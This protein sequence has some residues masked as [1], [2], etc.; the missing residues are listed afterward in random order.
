M[1]TMTAAQRRELE[2]RAFLAAMD[3]CPSRRVLDALSDKWVTLILHAL[4]EGPLRRGDLSRAVVGATQKVLTQTLRTL[5]REGYLTRTIVPSGPVRVE[6]ELTPLGHD[7]LG[8]VRTIRDWA[9]THI[10]EIE[11][12]QAGERLAPVA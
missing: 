8:L 2:R 3:E 6:Y 12:A 4:G 7:L 11:R 5:E 1:T 9:E 10:G